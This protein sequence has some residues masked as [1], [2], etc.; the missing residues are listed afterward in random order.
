MNE[1]GQPFDVAITA[2]RSGNIFTTHT[3]VSSG[4]DYFAPSLI[5]QYLGGYAEKNWIFRV[6][7]CSLLAV[8]I[9]VMIQRSSTWHIWQSGEADL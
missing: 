1:T 4:I 8:W 2:T 5:D 6:I 9:R 7:S 3:A